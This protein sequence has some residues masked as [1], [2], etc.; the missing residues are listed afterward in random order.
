MSA[1]AYWRLVRAGWVLAR[2]GALAITEGQPLPGGLKRMVGLGRL[3]ERRSVRRTGRVERLARALEKLGPTYVKIGQLLATRPDIVGVGI[4]ADLSALQDKMPPFDPALVPGILNEALGEQRAGE[5]RDISAPVAAASIAQVHKGFVGCGEG[6][7]RAVAI[8]IL[9][10]GIEAKFQRDLEAVMAWAKLMERF[11]APSRRLR[12]VAVAETLERTA[13]VEMDLRLEAAAISEMA[14]NTRHSSGFEVPEIEWAHTTRNVLTTS[15][16]DG[17]TIADHAALDAA[18]LDRR[19]IASELV[20][21]FLTH[22]IEHG[23]FHADMHP[24]N[25][26]VDP[27]T[28]AI[29]AVDFGIMGRIGKPEQRFLAEVV[30]GFIV[31]DY[32]RMARLHFE[33]GYVPA[34]QSVDAFAQALRAIGEPLSG[35]SARDISMAKVLAQLFEVTEMFD[36]AA[37]PE[38]VL[39]QKTMVVVEGVARSLDPDLDMWSTAEPVVGPWVR[40]QAGPIGQLEKGIELVGEVVAAARKVP[41][42][43]ARYEALIEQAEADRRRR[44]PGR[45]PLFF[46]AAGLAL[47]LV[48]VAALVAIF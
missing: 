34:H 24:G 10:P 46:V 32:R 5:L 40:R 1:G 26:F 7:K 11:S 29:G 19:R 21:H 12:P 30:Y 36:M 41:G 20:R 33:I 42:L 31:R 2:E 27:K 45:H 37:R 39:L 18:G 43:V 22:A 15:W 14:E 13:L 3:I 48:G 28:G 6:P 4:A 47:V 44:A 16:M 38:L 35:R 25:L 17:I 23:F 8:K 9:R